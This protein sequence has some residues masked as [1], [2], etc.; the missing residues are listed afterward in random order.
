VKQYQ[1]D[2]PS[3]HPDRVTR[4]NR[5]DLLF[6]RE[7]GDKLLNHETARRLISA[8]KRF[9]PW[10]RSVQILLIQSTELYSSQPD[11]VSRRKNNSLIHA[12]T[13]QANIREGLTSQLPW[14]KD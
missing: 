6:S 1:I 3:N 5:T 12:S 8:T 7:A 13:I 11:Q 10:S 4:K 2:E 9:R 14:D